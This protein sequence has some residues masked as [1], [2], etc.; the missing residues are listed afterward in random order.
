MG[1]ALGGRSGHTIDSA[2]QAECAFDAVESDGLLAVEALCV[3]L[4]QYAHAVTGPPGN[5]RGSDT[6]VEPR[7]DRRMP[8][9]VWP[10]GERRPVLRC[11]QNGPRVPGPIGEGRRRPTEAGPSPHEEPSLII[12]TERLERLRGRGRVRKR[13]RIGAPDPSLTA[14]SGVAAVEEFV[15]KLDVVGAHLPPLQPFGWFEPAVMDNQGPSCNHEVRGAP[16]LGP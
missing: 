3:D 16:N 2:R 13:V 8:Q 7:R 9:V 6:A 12:R 14:T 4:E 1:V 10:A 11:P 5:L 15:D